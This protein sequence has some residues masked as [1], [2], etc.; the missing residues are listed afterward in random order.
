MLMLS[1]CVGSQSS[2]MGKKSRVKIQ[3]SGSGAAA[4]VSPKEMMNLINE[5]LQ[6]ESTSAP[7]AVTSGLTCGLTSVLTTH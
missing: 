5:L 4:A 6:S 7:P 3:K 1:L 2:T